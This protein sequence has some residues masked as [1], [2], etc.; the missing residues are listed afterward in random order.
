[1]LILIIKRVY[2]TRTKLMQKVQGLFHWLR[3]NRDK[4]RTHLR[5]WNDSTLGEHPWSFPHILPWKVLLSEPYL[6]SKHV[7]LFS[8]KRPHCCQIK[9]ITDLPLHRTIFRYTKAD[10]DS[11]WSYMPEGPLPNFFKHTVSKT[12]PLLSKFILSRMKS[13]KYP[14]QNKTSPCAYQN[15][16][17]PQITVTATSISTKRSSVVGNLLHSELPKIAARNF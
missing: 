7:K 6:L 10:R 17:Q 2:S 15:A 9:G 12:Y 5:S 14:L 3:T 16:L 4:W 13:F 8:S 1:M 11:F